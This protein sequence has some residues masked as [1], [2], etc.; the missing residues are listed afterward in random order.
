MR[1]NTKHS[2]DSDLVWNSPLPVSNDPNDPRRARDRKRYVVNGKLQCGC[3][4]Q[5]KT[6]DLYHKGKNTPYG[7]AILCKECAC[8]RRREHYYKMKE[9]SEV[10]DEE[11][12][13][14]LLR[15]QLRRKFERKDKYEERVRR[16]K[17]RR[18]DFDNEQTQD[19][20]E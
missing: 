9:K 17:E 16:A 3:C 7:V 13:I 12:N 19:N 5:W 4:K 8:K 11:G 6:L 18:G 20:E 1:D 14:D 2:A 15:V 10:R